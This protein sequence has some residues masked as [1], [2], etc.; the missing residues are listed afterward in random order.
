[1]KM[2]ALSIQQQEQ[3]F[4]EYLGYEEYLRDTTTEPSS[5]EINNMEKIFCKSKILKKVSFT[6]VNI[7]NYQPLHP[8]GA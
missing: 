4:K 2:N 6:P 8:I 3:N 1:M 5:D 7:L